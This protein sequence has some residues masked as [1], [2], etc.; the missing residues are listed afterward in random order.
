MSAFYVRQFCVNPL[1]QRKQFSLLALHPNRPN[2]P[3]AEIREYLSR[4]FKVSDP[5]C[6]IL[7]GFSTAF[8]GGRSSGM[9]LIYDSVDAAKSFEKKYR[10]TRAGVVRGEE[11][12]GR[13][14]RKETKNRKKKVRGKAK[15]KVG[16]AGR[17]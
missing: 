12:K 6:V 11:R 16:A 9:G 15:T 4:R 5:Q 17:K 13:R 7:Y 2:I 3:K 14:G 8:G 1:L 10:L